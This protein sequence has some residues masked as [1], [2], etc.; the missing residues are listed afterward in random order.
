[1]LSWLSHVCHRSADG[2]AKHGVHNE[3]DFYDIKFYLNFVVTETIFENNAALNI[4]EICIYS[5]QIFLIKD[6]QEMEFKSV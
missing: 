5:F 4:S 2:S 1:M 6:R 3:K